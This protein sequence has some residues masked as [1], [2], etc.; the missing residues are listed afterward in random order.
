MNIFS[1]VWGRLEQCA[2]RQNLASY[3]PLPIP[4]TCCYSSNQVSVVICTVDT[5]LAR[6]LKSWLSNNPLEIIIIT[7]PEHVEKIRSVILNAIT[8]PEDFAKINLL[9]SPEKGKRAQLSVGLR[10]AR[11]EVLA[12]VDDHIMWHT[13]FLKG[14]LPC[15][16]DE[17]VGAVG[18]MIIPMIP[19]ERQD[20]NVITPWEVAAMRTA[21]WRNRH[22]K[23]GYAAN[24]WCFC[25]AGCSGVFRAEIL[26]VSKVLSITT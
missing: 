26:K 13:D 24:R 19:H 2:F 7:I 20:V 10:A 8:S 3:K 25:L 16:E 1:S 14:M 5:L 18:P 23:A 17:S 9:V 15:L 4:S 12:L 6:C 22:L 11:G 21:W